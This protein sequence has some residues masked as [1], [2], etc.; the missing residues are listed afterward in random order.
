MISLMNN[1]L[2]F[3]HFTLESSQKFSNFS[4]LNFINFYFY[5]NLCIKRRCRCLFYE[6]NC[7]QFG[8]QYL[9]VF[10][11]GYVRI[12][13]S[14]KLR[15]K[16]YDVKINIFLS[17]VLFVAALVTR[18]KQWKSDRLSH[19]RLSQIYRL[20]NNVLKPFLFIHV[21]QQFI[22]LLLPFGYG[23]SRLWSPS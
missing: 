22:L 21:L 1:K 14:K 12:T 7:F 19:R 2:F 20:A 15:K 5:K 4:N 9:W 6:M 18:C 10:L 23:P 16:N 13:S 17:F 11:K 8:E 3:D